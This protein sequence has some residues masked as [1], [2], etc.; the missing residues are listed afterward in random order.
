MSY[1]K[2]LWFISIVLIESV[3]ST[4]NNTS[5]PVLFTLI[6]QAALKTAY[7][8]LVI[9]LNL[10]DIKNSFDEFEDLEKAINQLTTGTDAMYSHRNSEA[11]NLKGKLNILH[12]LALQRSKDS[13]FDKV[14]D[15]NEFKDQLIRTLGD[16]ASEWKPPTPAP[17]TNVTTNTPRGKRDVI[18]AGSL[19][20]LAGFALSLFNKREL[21][22]IKRAAESTEGHQRYVAAKAEESLLRLSNLTAYTRGVYDTTMKIAKTQTDLYREIKRVG[23]E[24]EIAQMKRIF[25]SEFT[26]FLTGIQ[27]LIEGHF[28]PL[29]INPDLLQSTYD[30]IVNKARSE[31]LNPVSSDADT[32]FQSPTSVIGTNDGDLLIIV[33]I[34]LYSGSLMR[35]YRYV[36]APFPL[37]DNIVAT[38][39]HEKEYLALDPSGTVGKE[40]SATEILKCDR[41][42]RIHHCNGENVLQKNLEQLCLYNLYNQR[43]E[44]I[45]DFYNVEIGKVKSHAIQLSGNQF[46]ILVT[47]PTQLTWICHDGSSKVETI[48]GVYILTLTETCSKANTPDHVFNRNPHVVSSQQ[49]I[50]LTLIQKAE[51]WFQDIEQRFKGVDLE[52]I[53]EELRL[54]EEGPI[55]IQ[56]FRHR[57]ETDTKKFYLTI[58]DYVQLS[59][60]G[61]ATLYLTYLMF[62]CLRKYVFPKIPFCCK[63]CKKGSRVK[64]YRVVTRQPKPFKPSRKAKNLITE[65]LLK[66]QPSAPVSNLNPV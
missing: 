33:H 51:R 18:S 25:L 48:N 29:L 39:R 10:P 65:E 14:D 16:K 17:S 35:L 31:S 52:P 47:E 63:F 61:I 3:R 21:S 50:A 23:L 58:I 13:V 60:T 54:E 59:L 45:E 55:S 62:Q 64:Q 22:N 30:D 2:I 40:L 53:F 15:L 5:S 4:E 34:P 57:I 7:G 49:L 28:S 46:R 56:Q 36:A 38:I 66:V 1:K 44:E 24:T 19:F 6:S 37:R 32:L 42:N 26:L 11:N 20:Q 41:I 27:S 9:P 43:V 8:H 12:H